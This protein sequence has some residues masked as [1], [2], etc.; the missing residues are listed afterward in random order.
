MF[1]N[2][3]HIQTKSGCLQGSVLSTFLFSVVAGAI[4][5]YTIIVLMEKLLYAEY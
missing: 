4:T 2:F 5:Q 1:M 3:L